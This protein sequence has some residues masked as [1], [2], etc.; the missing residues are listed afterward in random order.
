[1]Y[2]PSISLINLMYTDDSCV[3]CECARQRKIKK[4]LPLAFCANVRDREK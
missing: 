1:M 3:L 2:A 4:S